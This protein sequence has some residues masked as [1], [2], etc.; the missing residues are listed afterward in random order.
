[1]HLPH[2]H[3][4]PGLATLSALVLPL[5]LGL[6][7]C[8][9]TMPA[10]Q[11]DA[12][13]TAQWQAPLPHQGTVGSLA[14]WWQ[15]Q[16]DPVLVELIEAAQAV[17]PSVA[18][19]MAPPGVDSMIMDGYLARALERAPDDL[20][21]LVLPVQRIGVSVEHEAYPGTLSLSFETAA[22]SWIEIGASVRRAGCRK[23]VILN[24]H[25]G[26]VAVIE[27]EDLEEAGAFADVDGEAGGLFGDDDARLIGE[28]LAP[29][30]SAAVLVWEDCWAAPFA[31]AVRG[32]GGIVRDGQR[33]P[34]DEVVAALA[35]LPPA[36]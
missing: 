27:Y 15:Q 5:S 4:I 16:G 18:Q 36:T 8:S 1:M 30:S 28:M 21:V 34:H 35:D 14:Q 11:V 3:R 33:I 17:S 22:R 31:A 13:V 29:D 23:L 2:S 20:P 10:T 19:A 6:G 25:G 7:A 32:A 26:N 12:P 24:S 9:I